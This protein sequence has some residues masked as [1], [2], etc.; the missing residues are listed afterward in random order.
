MSPLHFDPS[1]TSRDPVHQLI[2][3]KPSSSNIAKAYTVESVRNIQ[4]NMPDTYHRTGKRSTMRYLVLHKS[5]YVKS[6]IEFQRDIT[7]LGIVLWKTV[8]NPF[9]SH[10]V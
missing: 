8:V 4:S 3:T 5:K 7:A 1:K 6:S 2:R 10:Q 9:M